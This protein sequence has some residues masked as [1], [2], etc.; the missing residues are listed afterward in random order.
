[1][2][3]YIYIKVGIISTTHQASFM[4]HDIFKFLYYSGITISLLYDMPCLWYVSIKEYFFNV[5]YK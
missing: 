4:I 3:M 1:M 5:A 2:C